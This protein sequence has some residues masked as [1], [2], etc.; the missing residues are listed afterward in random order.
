MISSNK[1]TAYLN[2]EEVTTRN[3]T[4]ETKTYVQLT[5]GTDLNSIVNTGTY[6]SVKQA[7]TNTMQ[8]VPTGINGGFTMYVVT[9]T[10]NVNDTKF[11]RQEILYAR[12]SYVRHSN[13]GGA[14]WSA[15]NTTAYLE[16]IYPVGAVYCCSTNTN[17]SSKLGGTWVL[18]GKGFASTYSTDDPI[19]TPYANPNDN[20]SN[21][22]LEK[23]YII[24]N[25]SS[26]RMRINLATTDTM[27]D[28]GLTLGTI[29]FD[30]I[31]ITGLDM[32]YL[33]QA[34]FSDGA[35]GGIMWNL[36]Y[37]TGKLEQVDVINTGGLKPEQTFF[38]EINILT[39]HQK[40]IDSFCDK[41]YWKRTA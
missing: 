31:G 4:R 35:N 1:K 7:D 10:S 15:W 34:T 13:D 23:S 39:R 24:R 28:T 38:I 32:S 2:G 29:N 30:K 9:W 6:R 40:M 25:D 14:T 21:I 17:P 8:N 27:S 26:I 18:I 20:T 16:D 41:F 5:A 33:A 12:M 19:F 11:R 3:N 37:I 22:I 36:D